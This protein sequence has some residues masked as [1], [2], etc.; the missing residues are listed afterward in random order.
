M[1]LRNDLILV[2]GLSIALVGIAAATEPVQ[3]SAAVSQAQ[4]AA[5]PVGREDAGEAARGWRFFRRRRVHRHD[6]VVIDVNDDVH[7]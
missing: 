4:E 3:P 6:V 5:A 2:C 1:R 7:R